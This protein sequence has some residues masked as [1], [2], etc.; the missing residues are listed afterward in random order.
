M[1]RFYLLPIVG[2]ILCWVGCSDKPA[3]PGSSAASV[4]PAI[5]AFEVS[6]WQQLVSDRGGLGY[7]FASAR[8]IAFGTDGAVWFAKSTGGTH[9]IGPDG[10]Y[11]AFTEPHPCNIVHAIAVSA[12]GTVWAGTPGGVLRYGPDGSKQRI[13]TKDG[14]VGN[15]VNAVAVGP[16]GSV[17]F[18]TPGHGVT[19]RSPEGT[20]KAYTTTDGLANDAIRTGAI[21][22]MPDGSVWF[23]TEDGAGQLMPDG[24]WRTVSEKDG[25]ANGVVNAIERAPDGSMWFGTNSG[26][27]RRDTG[28][29]WQTY[30]T[31]DGL[32]H[33]EV[34]D[35]AFG[36]DGAV[37]FAF[38]GR[39]HRTPGTDHGV[40]RLAPDG[41]WTAL[42][43]EQGLSDDAVRAIAEGPRGFIWFSSYEDIT[44]LLPEACP[45]RAVRS[46]E[47]VGLGRIQRIEL[48]AD[49]S[50]WFATR[51]GPLRFGSDGSWRRFTTEDGLVADTVN[52]VEV[53]PD[54]TVWFGAYEKGL[55]HLSTDGSVRNYTEGN[56]LPRDLRFVSRITALQDGTVWI[57]TRKDLGRVLP[58][59]SVQQ[60]KPKDLGIEQRDCDFLGVAADGTIWAKSP[61]AFHCRLPGRSWK[62]LGHGAGFLRSKSDPRATAFGA[63]GS[64]WLSIRSRQRGGE[65]VHVA[66]DGTIQTFSGPAGKSYLTRIAPAGD[67]GVWGVYATG[68]HPHLVHLRP[69]GE[70]EQFNVMD[71]LAHNEVYAVAPLP[72]GSV[73]AVTK[74]GLNLYRP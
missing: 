6:R 21:Y 41:T 27:S 61:E 45:W 58:D 52:A 56:G 23:G 17:W 34:V 55:T 49:G 65:V 11:K 8:A 69:D 5:E 47:A 28:G 40:S 4:S 37:W 66:T 25:L 24:T 26:V 20:W 30:T 22:V 33:N 74:R 19:R 42:T 38:A 70:W 46:P 29:S 50:L 71:G 1:K 62:S 31:D 12:D 13:T 53:E 60:V 10:E 59:G 64:L 9:C 51:A 7:A 48:E 3:S 32:A 68:G 57:Q 39:G 72:G 18:G 44:R 36:S 67:R 73:L 54:G 2:L 16:D 14:L 63:D 15:H 35:I 43:S